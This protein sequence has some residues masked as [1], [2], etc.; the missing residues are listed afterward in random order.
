MGS[1]P[2]KHLL[3]GAH[4]GDDR[5]Y[6]LAQTVVAAL[7]EELPGAR[8]RVARGPRPQRIASLIG[9]GQMLTAVLSEAEAELMAE[10]RPPFDG[11]RPTPLRVLAALGAGYHLV[12]S[13]DLPEDHAW[14]VAQALSHAQVGHVPEG[15]ALPIHPGAAAF[16]GGAPRPS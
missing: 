16:W 7:G 1:L 2:Q 3:I 11:Y 14:L 10:A 4:R 15:V 9:T 13:P 6:E 8:A 12:A 5:T